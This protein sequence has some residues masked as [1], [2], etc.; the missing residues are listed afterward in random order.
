MEV[1]SILSDPL[2]W[3]LFGLFA[4]VLYGIAVF[5]GSGS[6]HRKSSSIG[7]RLRLR[8]RWRPAWILRLL[9]VGL[10]LLGLLLPQGKFAQ[11]EIPLRQVMIVDQSDSLSEA[12]RLQIQEQARAWQSEAENRLVVAYGARSH[13]VLRPDQPWPEIDGRASDLEGAL[14]TAE[15]LL[16]SAPGRAVL[17]TDGQ[18]SNPA[19]VD[20]ALARFVQQGHNLDVVPLASRADAGDGYVGPL[21]S[22]ANLW[23]GMPFDVILPVYP[24][25]GSQ[26]VVL[27]LK[28]NG[29][30]SDLQ[31]ELLGGNAYRFHVPAQ[32]EGITTLEASAEFVSAPDNP[33][34]FPANNAAFATLQVFAPPGVLFVTPQPASIQ[35][36][37]LVLLLAQNG[38]EVDILPPVRIPTDLQGLEKYRV[39]FLHNLLSSQLS[40]EQVLSLQVFVSRLAGGVVFLGG[41]S[42]YTLG[43]Y[44]NTLLEPMLPVKL[45]P[46]PRSKR[47]PIVFLLVLDHSASM[48]TSS[49]PDAPRPIA[50][51]REAAMRAIEAMQPQDWLG[52]LSFS[53]EFTWNVTMRE[54]GSG[55]TLREALDAV[56]RVEATGSTNMYAAMQEALA[57]LQNLPEGTPPSRHVLV[58]S[59]GQSF[60]G[61]QEEFRT[62]VEAAQAEGITFSSIAFG[63]EADQETMS[64]IAEAGKGRYYEVKQADDLP[65]ILV[66]ESQAARSENVQTG[67][68]SLKLGEGDHPILSGLR[69]SLLP[70]LSGYNALSSRSEEGAEDVLVSSSFG[71]PVLSTWQYGL[72]RVVAWTGD[73]GEEW[74][75][76][77]Q[78]EPQGRFWSQ[79]VRYALVNPAL[80]PVQVDVQAEETQLSVQAAIQGPDGQPANLAQVNFTYA[81][82]GDPANEPAARSFTVP[83]VSAGTYFLE[84]PRPPEGA[85]RAVVSYTSPGGQK[86]EV[87][88]AYAVD[89]PAEW[90]PVDPA[91]GQDH[92]AAWAKRGGGQVV[93]MDAIQ[94]LDRGPSTSVS[95][96]A[97]SGWLWVLLALVVL[98]PV[99]IALRRRWMP[100]Q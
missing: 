61:S 77:W 11:E 50:L 44:K 100:W 4:L 25:P 99:E 28:V 17:A 40:Q 47:P 81:E 57:G 66:Y 34:P 98:W 51:A 6:R 26:D 96:P 70:A 32:S 43:G 88:A 42:S 19:A 27:Q 20:A 87:P 69:T 59:D 53:S 14:Q 31:P 86:T 52:V 95:E 46:P 93:S 94:S 97:L 8:L 79:V 55:L 80:G 68:T 74:T 9:L 49:P 10:V 39:I 78:A 41:R 60:D 92:L 29:Q 67:Q 91:A 30:E 15:E 75:G 72:G 36:E 37:R 12:A 16:G 71:D 73:I 1:I 2:F 63:D 7:G 85:Y 58:L 35:A 89:P 62:L 33:D 38:L 24:P 56:S 76:E 5:A 45:E 83:Q 22:P 18:V 3:V 90:L 13:D 48:G 54:L 84:I 21:W 82:P 64:A 23:A 65:R